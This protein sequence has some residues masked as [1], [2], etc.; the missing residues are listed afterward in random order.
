[1]K[2]GSLADD[3]CNQDIQSICCRRDSRVPDSQY[4]VITMH[5]QCAALHMLTNGIV[6][7]LYKESKQ[8]LYQQSQLCL[9]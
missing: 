3:I 7:T 8:G 1:M 4:V 2:E 9:L 5:V 6:D